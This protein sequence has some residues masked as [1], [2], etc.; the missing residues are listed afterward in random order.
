M[1]WVE[2]ESPG[3]PRR[4]NRGVFRKF[5]L[6]ISV[7]LVLLGTFLVGNEFYDF[8]HPQ[9]NT[10][11]AQEAEQVTEDW[12]QDAQIKTNSSSEQTKFKDGETVGLIKI[13]RL[14]DDYTRKVVF[15][16]SGEDL[17]KGTGLYPSN[18]LPGEEGNM[19][20]AGHRTGPDAT[21]YDLPKIKK[22]DKIIIE[23]KDYVYTYKTVKRAEDTK[24]M[25]TDTWVLDKPKVSSESTHNLTLTTCAELYPNSPKRL[26][27]FAELDSKKEKA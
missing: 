11:Q 24:V 15:G 21:F 20:I 12:A 13:P 27:L 17:K 5:V 6:V 16:V 14:G 8:Y 1:K 23:T 10:S 7:A 19:A 25:D 9:E 18:A 26:A 22:G 2:S 3:S 4:K